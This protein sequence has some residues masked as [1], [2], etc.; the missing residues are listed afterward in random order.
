MPTVEVLRIAKWDS[1]HLMYKVKLAP[2]AYKIFYDCTA[3]SMGHILAK[4]TS[5]MHFLLT[6]NK[7]KVPRLTHIS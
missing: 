6:K 7:V 3:P 1:L 5:P 4:K 2:L